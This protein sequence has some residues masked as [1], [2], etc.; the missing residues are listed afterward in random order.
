MNLIPRQIVRALILLLEFAGYAFSNDKCVYAK[1][2]ILLGDG[3][4]G[5]STFLNV[6]TELAGEG[7]YSSLSAKHF[8]K[9]TYLVQLEG[10]LF[11][12]AEETPTGAFV[13]SS[14]FKNIV[15]GG[16]T[17][18]RKMYKDAY[19]TRLNAKLMMAAN[20]LP[21]TSDATKGFLRRLLIV[22]F[23]VEFSTAA[24]NKDVDIEIKLFKELPGILNR[25]IEGYRRLSA[26][27]G[28]T[29]SNVVKEAVYAYRDSIDNIHSYV[30]DQLIIKDYSDPGKTEFNKIYQDYV[31]YCDES[32][33][34]PVERPILSRKLRSYI[35]DYKTRIRRRG[36][37]RVTYLHGV[38]MQSSDYGF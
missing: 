1:A 16:S 35:K 38:F 7:A 14:E 34:K 2:L 21:R 4:N 22:P 19:T 32:R 31:K 20:D 11:N 17:I 15:S 25:I 27:K 28:F 3:T 36:K 26:Q 33:A 6:L 10:K 37:H 12:L 30:R 13:D 23:D 5:K 29:D 18:V 9:E 24:G 8:S